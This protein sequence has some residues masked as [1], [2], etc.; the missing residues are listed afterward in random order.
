MRLATIQTPAGPRAAVR[1]GDHYVDL[2]GSDPGLST[3]VRALLEGG[4]PLLQKA[5]AVAGRADAVKHP[6]ASV[7]LL[8]PIPDP[9]KIICVGLNYRDHAA[10]SG[11]KIP[12]EPILFSKYTTALIG[13]GEAIVVPSVSQK[14]DYE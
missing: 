5:A 1:Q 12:S 14:V 8:A 6:A 13:P 10:E 9:A 4:P 7:K 3:R 11:A 2:H